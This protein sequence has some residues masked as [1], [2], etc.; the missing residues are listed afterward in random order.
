[1]MPLF[2]VTG[3]SGAGKTTAIDFISGY[4]KR[5]RVYVGQLINDEVVR[6][7]LLPGADS[8]RIVR[9]DFR[10]RHGMAGLAALAASTIRG[11]LERGD[12]VFVDAV[13]SVEELD[14]YREHCDH[15]AQLISIEASFDVRADR[16]AIR[17]DKTLTR[18]ELLKRDE[19]ERVNLRTDLAIASAAIS[20][21]NEGSLSLFQE[22]LQTQV[23]TLIASYQR[24]P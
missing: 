7:G 12:T 24:C 17:T 4:P 1:M 14:Y 19:L 3:F 9:L 13:Y 6:R 23:C 21:R 22:T 5:S 15:D 20:I 11:D 2:A 18:D 8:E 10:Q 16:V